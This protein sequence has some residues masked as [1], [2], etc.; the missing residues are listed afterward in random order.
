MNEEGIELTR[1]AYSMDEK[2]SIAL[3]NAGWYY[4]MV[5]NDIA[6]GYD[7]IKGAYDDISASLDEETKKE[8][9]D[10]YNNVKKV[11]EEFLSDDSQEFDLSGINLIY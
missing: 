10:N 5:E 11:Y 6:R 2:D 7:N 4:L 1:K 8:I 3:N 9:I